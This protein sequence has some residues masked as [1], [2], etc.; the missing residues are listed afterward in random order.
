MWLVWTSRNL[1]VHEGKVEEPTSIL[2][3]AKAMLSVKKNQSQLLKISTITQTFEIPDWISP[4]MDWIK[5]N[6]D[7]SWNIDSVN[8]G[9]GFV[10]RSHRHQF[11]LAEA[12]YISCGSAEE[13]EIHTIKEAMKKTCERKDQ[14]V[15]IESNVEGIIQKINRKDFNGN[16]RTQ[17]LFSDIKYLISRFRKMLFTFVHGT[18]NGAA[19]NVALWA[20]TNQTDMA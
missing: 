8:G 4:P 7:G 11:V 16:H 1:I 12:I 13:A 9:G 6:C 20:K 15:V 2:A 19:H 18:S 3:R 10:I 14:Q 5:I 17:I